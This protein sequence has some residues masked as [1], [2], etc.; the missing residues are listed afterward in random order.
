MSNEAL[1][2][3]FRGKRILLD[4]NLL[5]LYLIGSFQ[6]GRIEV[7][8]RTAHFTLAEFD[9]LVALLAQFGTIVTT[10]HLLTE[11]SNLANSLPEYIK[12]DWC[13]HFAAKTTDFLEILDPAALIMKESC[14][15]PYGLADAALQRAS[16]NTLVVTDDFRLSGF[17][18][19]RGIST[20]N[21]RELTQTTGL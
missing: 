2:Q 4:A 12:S 7:F 18:R 15:N 5:L 13:D 11:V 14:F 6:R 8:K 20:L 3:L 21:F 9:S 1:F 10:P 16:V 17:L 19:D